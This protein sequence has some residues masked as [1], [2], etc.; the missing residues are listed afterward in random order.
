VI[1]SVLDCQSFRRNWIWTVFHKFLL[2]LGRLD[3]SKKSETYFQG[4]LGNYMMQYAT[5]LAHS[6]RLG[7]QPGNE[8]NI[9]F[10]NCSFYLIIVIGSSALVQP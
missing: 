2:D 7:V 1:V 4:R 6:N 9:S 5:L 3:D 10:H 8:F